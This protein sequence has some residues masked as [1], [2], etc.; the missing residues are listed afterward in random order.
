VTVDPC[1]CMQPRTSDDRV[2]K[3]RRKQRHEL[4]PVAMQ[5]DGDLLAE[6]QDTCLPR[7]EPPWV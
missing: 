4:E 6:P 5:L 1:R 3:F 7:F 2:E